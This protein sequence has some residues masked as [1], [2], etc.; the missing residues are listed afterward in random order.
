MEL[1]VTLLAPRGGKEPAVR[2]AM[3]IS[4]ISPSNFLGML[5]DL[6]ISLLKGWIAV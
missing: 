2:L 1:W 5:V 4:V 6:P 3:S